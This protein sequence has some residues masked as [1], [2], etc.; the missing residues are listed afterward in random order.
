MDSTDIS[1]VE[2]RTDEIYRKVLLNFD[3]KKVYLDPSLSL[4]K[5]S[6]IVGTNTTYLSNAINKYCGCNLRTFINQYRVET[7]KNLL[8]EGSC[9]MKELYRLCGFASRSAFY[10]AFQRVAETSPL[11]YLVELKKKE[12]NLNRKKERHG[13]E[14][15]EVSPHE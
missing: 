10:A 6:E 13:G 5:L 14:Y 8:S 11:G 7:A 9:N 2:I 1:I 15:N 12:V 4:I 3:E